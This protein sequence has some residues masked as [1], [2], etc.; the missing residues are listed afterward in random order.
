MGGGCNDS[1]CAFSMTTFD[2]NYHGAGKGK[3][4]KSCANYLGQ[5]IP[6]FYHA[7]S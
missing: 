4:N 2:N 5:R 7:Q 1:R 3:Q 6:I